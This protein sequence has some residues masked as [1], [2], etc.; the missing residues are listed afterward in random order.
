MQDAEIQ[1]KNYQTHYCE[2][3]WA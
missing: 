3:V 2:N 1:K